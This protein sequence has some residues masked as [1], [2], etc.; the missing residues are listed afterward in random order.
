MGVDEGDA[1]DL[2]GLAGLDL[3]QVP[4]EV[5]ALGL[6]G[7]GGGGGARGDAEVDVGAGEGGF[8]ERVLRHG[9]HGAHQGLAGRR[10]GVE[11]EGADLAVGVGEGPVGGIVEREM[12]GGVVEGVGGSG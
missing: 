11:V 2:D 8:G 5:G 4:D 7:A 10:A 6:G 12:V 3:G 9:D 1:R